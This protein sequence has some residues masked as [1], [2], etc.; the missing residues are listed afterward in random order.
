MYAL[1][2]IVCIWFQSLKWIGYYVS[3]NLVSVV[4]QDVPNMENPKMLGHWMGTK[5]I[6]IHSFVV[7]KKQLYSCLFLCFV[8]NFQAPGELPAERKGRSPR[9][10]LQGKCI[11][12]FR[13][14]V[15]NFLYRIS[16]LR[17]KTIMCYFC[18]AIASLACST[19]PP[20]LTDF[21]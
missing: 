15:C 17:N 20:T 7:K 4:K 3:T 12:Y 9:F 21:L 18:L 11:T 14:A 19:N 6:L 13:K 8:G 10:S 16:H 5:W 2:W 1:K